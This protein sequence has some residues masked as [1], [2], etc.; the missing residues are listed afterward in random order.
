MYAPAAVAFIVATNLVIWLRT[1]CGSAPPR[2]I[3]CRD[4]YTS[5]AFKVFNAIFLIIYVLSAA[6]QYNDPDTLLW[7]STY[8]SAAAM[9][10]LQTRAKLPRWLPP[11][12]LVLS[13]VWIGTLLPSIVGQVSLEEIFESLS[14]KTKAVEEAREIGGLC[15]VGLWAGVLAWHQRKR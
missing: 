9:C 7:A 3:I 15:L 8:L 14:M 6:V 2:R 11:A 13:V 4:F 1:A 5:M 10:A 12:L